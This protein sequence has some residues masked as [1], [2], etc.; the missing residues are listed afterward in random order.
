MAD[1]SR[2]VLHFPPSNTLRN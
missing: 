2:T 1:G